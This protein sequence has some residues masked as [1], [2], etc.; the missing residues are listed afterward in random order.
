MK[1]IIAT[2][3]SAT[4]IFSLAGCSKVVNVD[5]EKKPSI[6]A[7]DFVSY[8]TVRT[9]IQGTDLQVDYINLSTELSGRDENKIKNSLLF[10]NTNPTWIN[11]DLLKD[12]TILNTKD[13]ITQ[14]ENEKENNYIYD[15][16]YKDIIGTETEDDNQATINPGGESSGNGSQE[17]NK[18]TEKPDNN[19]PSSGE[20]NP[21]P[22]PTS[23]PEA[24]PTPTQKPVDG[25]SKPTPTPKPVAT[26]KPT[27]IPTQAVKPTPTQKPKPTPTNI[28]KPVI[29]KD[30]DKNGIPDLNIDY[31][32][33]GKADI[34][35]DSNNDNIGDKNKINKDINKDGRADLN[36]DTNNDGYPDINI[37]IDNDNK[38][39]INIDWNNDN[40][41]DFNLDKNKDGKADKNDI[42]IDLDKNGAADI[43]IDT[44]KDGIPDVNIDTNRDGIPDKNVTP[45]TNLFYYYKEGVIASF[46]NT[47]FDAPPVST[48]RDGYRLGTFPNGYSLEKYSEGDKNFD[49]YNDWVI[50]RIESLSNLLSYAALNN[51]DDTYTVFTQNGTLRRSYMVIDEKEISTSFYG[52]QS[53]VYTES[54]LIGKITTIPKK[55]YMYKTKDICTNYWLDVKNV[56]LL[57]EKIYYELIKI[58]PEYKTIIEENKIKYLDELKSLDDKIQK[59][60]NDSEN[61]LLFIGGRNIYK[62]LCDG[63]KINYISIY[64][65]STQEI[66]PSIDKLLLYS[67]IVDKYNI[68]YIIKDKNS[69]SEGINNVKS[70][71]SHNINIL[72]IEDFSDVEDFNKTYI[73]LMNNNYIIINKSLY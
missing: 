53:N 31:D 7:T 49:V 71:V 45:D 20:Q 41:A 11:D 59:S 68:K 60:V 51:G 72:L 15:D 43:N 18:P 17:S 21:V 4:L 1:K 27:P 46:V 63:Y 56:S 39:D 57:T 40:K 9:L 61:Q 65:Y 3:M 73:E 25:G 64:D 32:D 14:K 33:D 67:Y 42:N 6:I 24:K 58:K 69:S 23:T 8:D 48:N 66:A 2:I 54:S 36:I 35:I 70:E 22:S 62:Y 30:A 55:T 37:D 5:Y 34:N 47:Y 50:R 16:K 52:P 38:P 12:K 44:N 29:N 26:Q 10:I 28:P 13:F 19:K